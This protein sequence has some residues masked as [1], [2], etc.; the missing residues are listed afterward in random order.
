[1]GRWGTS[2]FLAFLDCSRWGGGG[3]EGLQLLFPMSLS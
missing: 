3:G 1:M 2:A